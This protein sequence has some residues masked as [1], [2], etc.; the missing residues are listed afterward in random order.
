MTFVDGTGLS[1]QVFQTST[2]E[3][4]RAVRRNGPSALLAATP[5]TDGPCRADA[6]RSAERG[7]AAAG[8]Q[9]RQGR[10]GGERVA[11]AAERERLERRKQIAAAAPPR[12]RFRRLSPPREGAT[13][14]GAGAQGPRATFESQQHNMAIRSERFY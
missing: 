5:S 13:L 11:A 8:R 3:R 10:T 7:G 1:C 9:G 14:L 6:E 12:R 4:P 2:Y